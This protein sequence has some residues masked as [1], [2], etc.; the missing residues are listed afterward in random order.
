MRF[1]ILDIYKMEGP[2]IMQR[3]FLFSHDMNTL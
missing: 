3:E 2:I 1:K